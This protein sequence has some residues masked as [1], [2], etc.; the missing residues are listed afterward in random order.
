MDVKTAFLHGSLKEEVY[1]EQP[2]GFE[3]QDRRTHVCRLKKSL[4]GL[5]QSPRAWYERIDNYLMKFGFTRS[6]VNPNLYFNS[7]ICW[8][9][10]DSSCLDLQ[11]LLERYERTK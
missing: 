5:K 7:S 4:Y 3:V 10:L 8:P 9:S 11:A 6:S 2:Q 1:L